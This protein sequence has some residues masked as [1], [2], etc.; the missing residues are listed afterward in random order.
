MPVKRKW[1]GASR[2]VCQAWWGGHGSSLV[3]VCCLRWEGNLLNLLLKKKN[4]PFWTPSQNFWPCFCWNDILFYKQLWA[5][6]PHSCSHL[7]YCFRVSSSSLV[8]SL[9]N[10]EMLDN[11]ARARMH[12]C[13]S[14]DWGALWWEDFAEVCSSAIQR[15][16][17]PRPPQPQYGQQGRCSQS[18]TLTV[19]PACAAEAD[20]PGG[21]RWMDGV[22]VWL[23]RVMSSRDHKT[24]LSPRW[25][26]PPQSWN[27]YGVLLMCFPFRFPNGSN[28]GD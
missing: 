16:R 8:N 27:V 10:V 21:A 1:E 20:L 13:G 18:T 19:L 5:P 24:V 6:T 12:M 4:G 2:P 7:S 14:R 17:A 15:T 22:W 25:Q 28:N 9:Q 23:I 11:C 3:P 26:P